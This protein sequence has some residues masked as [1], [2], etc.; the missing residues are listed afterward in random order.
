M[1]E[2]KGERRETD[3][4]KSHLRV[5]A[6]CV[7]V[8]L[9]GRQRATVKSLEYRKFTDLVKRLLKALKAVCVQL[10]EIKVFF[11]ILSS[12]AGMF[13]SNGLDIK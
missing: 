11:K 13:L 9:R 10:E 2:M 5:S 6:V 3:R 12:Q 8:G 1:R 4:V 7:C